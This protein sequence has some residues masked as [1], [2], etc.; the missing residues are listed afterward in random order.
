MNTAFSQ[1]YIDEVSPEFLRTLDDSPFTEQQ[2]T[3]FNEGLF[4]VLGR[5]LM[6]ED[7]LPLTED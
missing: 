2:L 1:R 7:F 6:A 5:S 3:E 4:G